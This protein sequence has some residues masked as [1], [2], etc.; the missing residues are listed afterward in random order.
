MESSKQ[1]FLELSCQ[2]HLKLGL[3]TDAEVIVRDN[4]AALEVSLLTA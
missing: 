1:E 3:R 4:F 2:L